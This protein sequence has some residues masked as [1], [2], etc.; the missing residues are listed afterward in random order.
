MKLIIAGSRDITDYDALRL[1]LMASGLWKKHKKAIEVVSGTARG[2]DT[3]GEI[4][5]ERN[6]LVLH[7]MAADWDTYGKR[8]GYLRNAEMADFADALLLIWDGKSKG[9]QHMYDLAK[10]KGLEVHAFIY[11]GKGADGVPI[12]KKIVESKEN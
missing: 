3:L 7:S 11:E 1:A 10:K 2:V 4:F 8:A 5:A 12:M 9:S 6:G